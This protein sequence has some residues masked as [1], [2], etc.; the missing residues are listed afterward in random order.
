[1]NRRNFL[2]GTSLLGVGRLSG[3]TARAEQQ[4]KPAQQERQ[5]QEHS[6]HEQPKTIGATVNNQEEVQAPSE[7]GFQP[8]YA[9]DLSKL[10]YKLED[11]VKVFHLI[12]EPTRVEFLPK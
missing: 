8:I 1:M 5:H 4:N 6:Q 10:P 12:A 11:G 3:Q 7:S 9:P 2:R